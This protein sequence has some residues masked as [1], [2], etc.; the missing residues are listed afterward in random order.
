[1]KVRPPAQAGAFYAG[2]EDALKRQ[3]ESC[4]LHKFG[5]GSIPK[6]NLPGQRRVVSLV[7]P[8]AG[9]MYSGPTAANGYHQ[10]ASDGRPDIFVLIGPN[11]TGIGSGVS[12]MQE[13]AWRT[14]L[15]DV[16]IDAAMAKEIQRSSSYIDIDDSSH[17]HEHSIEV[18]LPFLQYVYGSFKFVPICMMMQDLEVSLDVGQAVASAVSRKNAAVIASTDLSHYVAQSVAEE[19][20]RLVID[21]ILK[22][23]EARLQSVVEEHGISMCGYGPTSVAIVAAKKLGTKDTRLLSYKTSGDITGDFSQV[24]GYASVVLAK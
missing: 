15:G 5:P 10:L 13:G 14:P 8:H 18:Q 16:E 21:A 24:V 1:V 20:D 11:H 6:V 17:L 2:S 9:Y 7:C 19:K 4:F 12:I 23:D 3:I 22:L